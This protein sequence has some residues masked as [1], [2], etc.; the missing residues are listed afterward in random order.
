MV[1]DNFTFVGLNFSPFHDVI[2]IAYII[3][4]YRPSVVAINESIRIG[5]ESV[6]PQFNV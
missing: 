5:N 3:I 4:L 6:T 1:M 2:L